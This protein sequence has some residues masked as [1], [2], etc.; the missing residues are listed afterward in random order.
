MLANMLT[1]IGVLGVAVFLVFSLIVVR[2]SY[3][4]MRSANPQLAA[5]GGALLAAFVAFHVE[6]ITDPIYVTTT[7]Y[8][9]FWF[10]IGLIGALARIDREASARAR[11]L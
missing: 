11:C 8:F 3:R 10:Q 1:E 2:T 9:F 4:V 6:G 5:L 7:T